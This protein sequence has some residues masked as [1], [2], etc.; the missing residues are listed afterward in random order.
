MRFCQKNSI[1]LISDEVY[2]LSVYDTESKDAVKFKSV[3]SIETNGLI[4]VECVHVLYGMRKVT[5][6]DRTMIEC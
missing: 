1:H 2:G 4:D 6:L 3:L 5:P